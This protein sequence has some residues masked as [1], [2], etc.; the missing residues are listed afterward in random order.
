MRYIVMCGGSAFKL[1]TPKPMIEVGGEML[2]ER[3]IR[4]LREAGV[5]DIAISSTDIRF[6]GFGVPLLMHDNPEYTS[7][8]Y[9]WLNAFF[10]AYEPTCYI[11][12]DVYFSPDA[13]QK[14]VHTETK[15]IEFFASAPPFSKYYLRRWAEPFAFKVVNYKRFFDCIKLTKH[16]EDLGKFH[17]DAIS[18]ELWQVIKDTPLNKILY[19]NYTVINDYTV[20]VDD[21]WDI[22]QIQALAERIKHE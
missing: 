19:D 12:G 21:E 5:S 4:L 8:R 9:R 11:F 1:S 6:Q 20:D 10:P 3:T 13:I 15:D 7:A 2:F 14:I 18:W 17:R 22:E 16:Y